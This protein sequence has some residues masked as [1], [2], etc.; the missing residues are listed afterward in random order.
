[1]NQELRTPEALYVHRASITFKK[2]KGIITYNV[3]KW[4]NPRAKKSGQESV[5]FGIYKGEEQLEQFKSAKN[6]DE[7][8]AIH[9]L[10]AT[11]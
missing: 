5:A 3:L 9:S 7:I 8:L 6:L 2:T 11:S 10:G 1:L 4:V